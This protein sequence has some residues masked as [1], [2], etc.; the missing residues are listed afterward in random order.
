MGQ[1]GKGGRVDEAAAWLSTH[2]RELFDEI[3][4]QDPELKRV[5]DEADLMGD[6][7]DYQIERAKARF[8]VITAR[9]MQDVIRRSITEASRRTRRGNLWEAV[10]WFATTIFSVT[11]VA[12]LNV[13]NLV[14]VAQWT[15]VG[16]TISALG[17][18]AAERVGR[19]SDGEKKVTTAE[20]LCSLVQLDYDLL[21]CRSELDAL[22]LTQ[23]P[24]QRL[25]ECINKTNELCRQANRYGGLL[26]TLN[27]FRNDRA[28]G[29]GELN[30]TAAG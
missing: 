9:E 19:L 20:A 22:L 30:M 24:G 25:L 2:R 8:M 14:N 15:A 11:T 29:S 21:A 6:E 5:F 28:T 3:S 10:A 27:A 17:T 7:T 13:S 16:S 1:L 4:G 26:E 18:F 12:A 23:D